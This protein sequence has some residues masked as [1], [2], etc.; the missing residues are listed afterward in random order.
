M[1]KELL[2]LVESQ[3]GSL[4]PLLFSQVFAASCVWVKLENESTFSNP[5]LLFEEFI[6]N[7]ILSS[8][9]LLD[10]EFPVQVSWIEKLKFSLNALLSTGVI[11]YQDLSDA[12][13][14]LVD[15]SGKYSS[16]IDI[17]T[18]VVELGVKLLNKKISTVYCP[19]TSGY[20][21]A[22]KIGS[23]DYAAC[24]TANMTDAF[25][26]RI[27]TLLLDQNVNI[28]VS[29]PI[30][31][32]TLIGEGG[33]QQF[34]SAIA[35]P[36]FGVKYGKDEIHDI[37]GRFPEKSLMGDVY[38]LRHLL[39]HSDYVVCFVTNGFLFRTAAG[40]KQFKQDMI[41]HNWLKAVISL[42][43]N[44]LSNTSIPIS[45][46]ILDKNKSD[47]CVTFIDATSDHFIDKV[48]RVKYKLINIDSILTM[49]ASNKDSQ[50]CK[51]SCA[52]DIQ[53]N[54]YNLSP[55][56]YTK[57]PEEIEAECFLSQFKTSKLSDLTD[58]IRPQAINHDENGT[59]KFI[60]HNL[61]SLNNFGQLVGEG[62]PI[63]VSAENIKKALKQ[64]IKPKDVLIS[65][66]GAVGRIALVDSEI[67]ENIL[68]SQ[69][70]A[71][72]RIKPDV[73]GITS[74]S[75]YQYLISKHGQVMLSVYVTGTTAQ[76]LN[77]KD[78][79]DI[80]I[81]LFKQDKLDELY[82]IR[83]QTIN[84]QKKISQIKDEIINLNSNWVNS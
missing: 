82:S 66:R 63:F 35:L 64:T 55:S 30:K 1:K 58:I 47:D 2:S 50:Y 19:F 15:Q 53:H 46:V 59:N 28:V 73:E 65:C 80:D 14:E 3:R 13:I 25:F 34:D 29:D 84:Y 42:P 43:S 56:R 49:V 78:L 37:W 39:A 41:E 27:Q 9:L 38:H 69:A 62:K 16:E 10:Y 81:P 61:T 12:I 36:P 24:E 76:M 68:A 5:D 57:T 21:F 11:N 70:F 72:V 17:P 83:I 33:L 79:G 32:P 45:L 7:E 23:Y 22:H 40:E 44:L 74:E 67:K 60:E 6:C 4:S 52:L 77:A 71:I 75:L 54:D 51:H 18:E 20:L 8:Y 26:G 48:S 31:T